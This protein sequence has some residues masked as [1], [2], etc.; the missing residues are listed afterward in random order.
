MASLDQA[1]KDMKFD[2][3]LVELNINLGQLKREEYKAHIEQLPDC[4]D[5]SEPLALDKHRHSS[6]DAH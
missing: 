2:K 5:K 6:D 4:T 3:R 1:M